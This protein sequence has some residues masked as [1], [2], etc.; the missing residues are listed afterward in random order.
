M[1][2]ILG[3]STI[4]GSNTGDE[5]TSSIKS[6]L[7]ITTL[8]GARGLTTHTGTWTAYDGSGYN[9]TNHAPNNT[10]TGTG[11]FAIKIA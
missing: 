10:N 2:S 11:I 4:S 5:T 6:K 9:T 3:I 8:R 7:G 1:R